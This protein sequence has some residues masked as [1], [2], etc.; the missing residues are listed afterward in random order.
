MNVQDEFLRK[1]IR[2]LHEELKMAR[3]SLAESDMKYQKRIND[4]LM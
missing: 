2:N 1:E 4:A 3:S